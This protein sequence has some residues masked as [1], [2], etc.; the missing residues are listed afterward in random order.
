MSSKISFANRVEQAS[1]Y[2]YNGKLSAQVQLLKPVL[3]PIEQQ[4]FSRIVS[5]FISPA[6]VLDIAIHVVILP[7][8]VIYAIGKSIYMRKC[9]FILPWQHIQ[10]IRDAVFPVLFGSLFGLIHPYLGAYA[11]E[12]TKKHIST[13]I[14]LS[15]TR[16]DTFDS[17]CSPITTI[18]EV[19]SLLSEIPHK[20]ISPDVKK[21]LNQVSFWEEEFEKIQ[22]IDFFN[23]NLTLK[24]GNKIQ[25]AIDESNLPRIA[26]EIVKRISLVT[27]P[28]F[29]VLDLTVFVFATVV[30]LGTLAVKIVGGQSPG[31]LEKAWTPEVLIYNIVKI[32]LFIISST[33]GFIVS[34]VH[35][36]AGLL[37]VQYSM[38]WMAKIPFLLKMLGLKL[39]LHTMNVGEFILVPAVQTFPDQGKQASLLPSYGSHMRYLLIEKTNPNTYQAELIERGKRHGKTALLPRAEMSAL[40]QKTLA[41]RYRFGNKDATVLD[42]FNDKSS[43]IDLGK[44]TKI[45]NCVVTNLFGAIQVLT[46]RFSSNNFEAI[47][48]AVK[49]QATRRYNMYA[50]DFYL[51]GESKDL[52]KEGA[53]RAYGTI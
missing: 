48:I 21:L 39:R 6:A 12:P 3:L 51:F 2:F 37:C 13:S 8:S 35:P 4:V 19:S 34:I 7:F 9:D 28:I 11:A 18:S 24:I 49:E 29:T 46:Y 47:C 33:I 26:K 5:L 10:R 53:F 25:Q 17:V 38:E 20:F 36:K 42:N 16:K 30:S 14:L 1:L 27:Y 31:Y 41:L 44:Q 22:S 23:L 15:G 52:V 40:M 43:L 32:P 50:S 45:N